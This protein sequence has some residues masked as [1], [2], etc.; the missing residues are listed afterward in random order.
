MDSRREGVGAG[1]GPKERLGW[2]VMGA[3]GGMGWVCDVDQKREGVGA[4]LGLKEG[5]S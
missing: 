1:L 4:G 2:S 5:K 3:K